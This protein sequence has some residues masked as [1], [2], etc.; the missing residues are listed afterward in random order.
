MDR[1]ASAS[2]LAEATNAPKRVTWMKDGKEVRELPMKVKLTHDKRVIG[3]DVLDCGVAD[4]GQYCVI[5]E[6]E[7]GDEVKAAFSLN[8]NA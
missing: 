2:F 5:L 1:G 3:L 7:K 6:G 8:V 4:A